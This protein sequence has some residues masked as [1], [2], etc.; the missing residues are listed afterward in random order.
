MA[1]DVRERIDPELD[2]KMEQNGALKR[3][4]VVVFFFFFLFL[5]LPEPQTEALWEERGSIL[6]HPFSPPKPSQLLQTQGIH[7]LLPL[8][9]VPVGLMKIV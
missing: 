5:F 4:F 1:G 7:K 2:L 3:F 6:S 9:L 8:P